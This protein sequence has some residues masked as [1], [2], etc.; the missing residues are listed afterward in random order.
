VADHAA[1]VEELRSVLA[2]LPDHEVPWDTYTAEGYQ[3]WLEAECDDAPATTGAWF[4][5]RT[6]VDLCDE[7]LAW[8]KAH[9]LV[10]IRDS[11]ATP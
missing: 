4:N 8:W 6:W 3:V 1:A 11:G 7:C 5:G 2:L 10:E 9:A